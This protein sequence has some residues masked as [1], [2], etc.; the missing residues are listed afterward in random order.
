MTHAVSHAPRPRA[1]HRLGASVRVHL[2]FLLFGL[3]MVAVS[4]GIKAEFGAITQVDVILLA[5][6][7]LL[8]WPLLIPALLPMLFFRVA[9]YEKAASPAKAL[10]ASFKPFFT[11]NGRLVPGL[12]ML[13]SVSLFMAGFASLKAS[14]T[15]IQPFAWDNSF[16]FWDRALHLGYRPW[17]LLQP[18]LGYGPVT[19]AININYHFWFLSLTMFWLHFGFAEQS[20]FLRLRA[21]AAFMLTWSVGGV[22]LATVFSSAGPCFYG[23]AGLTPDPYVPLM[24]YLRETAQHYPV[25]AVDLQDELWRNFANH[26]TADATKGIS[27]MPSMHNAQCL[28]LVLAAWNKGALVRNLAIGHGVLVFLGSIHLGWHYAVDA[29]LAFAVAAVAWIL[30]GWAARWWM[31]R[32]GQ[33]A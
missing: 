9:A 27:A 31:T 1:V 4:F 19:A 2:P 14:I 25:W 5:F 23:L 6:S 8:F 28:L 15:D 17:E 26:G 7:L 18:L 20:G 32:T 12:L 11:A 10:L 22:V 33:T 24:S 30:S 21:V 16:D 3:T 29:Y 13:L